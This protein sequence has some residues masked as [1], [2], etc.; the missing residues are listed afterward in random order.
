MLEFQGVYKYNCSRI[1]ILDFDKRR[2]MNNFKEII[3]NKK[4]IGNSIP[5]SF[6]VSK[7][8]EKRYK[9]LIL[10]NLSR[11]MKIY[12]FFVLKTENIKMDVFFKKTHTSSMINH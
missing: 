11:T 5:E 12:E 7:S 3:E 10:Q 9:Q 6:F 1:K 8:F 2:N 4:T